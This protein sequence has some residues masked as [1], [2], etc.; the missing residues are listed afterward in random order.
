[1]A[2]ASV[3]V[4]G[5]LGDVFAGTGHRPAPIVPLLDAQIQ[6]FIEQGFVIV[7]ASTLSP[8]FHATVLMLSAPSPFNST[9]IGH[10]YQR[11]TGIQCRFDLPLLNPLIPPEQVTARAMALREAD[12]PGWSSNNCFPILPEL[13]EVLK[14]PHV[15]GALTGL[16]GQ[17]YAM[18]PHR[19]CHQSAHGNRDQGIHQD[20]YEDDSQVRH[21]KPR[22]C[23]AMYYPQDVTPDLGPT[24][25][26]PGSHWYNDSHRIGSER[27]SDD[28]FGKG[29]GTPGH[30]CHETEEYHAVVPAGSVVIVHY[31]L[32]VS[33]SDVVSLPARK[34]ICA[35]ETAS[36]D[37]V[38]VTT[39]PT[40]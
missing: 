8:E 29:S 16:L 40:V 32:W 19:H 34:I 11:C 22:W 28:V 5:A 21:H 30:W 13:G 38:E 20:S 18:H 3:Q 27:S 35:Q 37:S 25:V 23:M 14:E 2:V 36:A 6:S 26:V 1:M 4:R 9:V 15:H 10:D 17:G 7:R 12:K 39:K 33:S 31:E 24:A